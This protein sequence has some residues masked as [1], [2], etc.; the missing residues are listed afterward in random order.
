MDYLNASYRYVDKFLPSIGDLNSDILSTN[1]LTVEGF[2]FLDISWFHFFH[3]WLFLFISSFIIISLSHIYY[4]TYT[5]DSEGLIKGKRVLIVIAHPDDECMFFGPTIVNLTKKNDVDVHLM[6][7]SEGNY[8]GD[9]ETR[10]RELLSSCQELGIPLSNIR[11][12][13]N[14]HLPDDPLVDW[15]A[16]IVASLISWHVEALSMDTLL[17]FDDHGVSGHRNHIA[18]SRSVSALISE[19]RLPPSCK[20]YALKSENIFFK[21]IGF[22]IVFLKR[23]HSNIYVSSHT[24]HITIK[25]AMSKHASQYVWFRKLFVTF[26]SYCYLNTLVCLQT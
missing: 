26:S 16:E 21:Y 5:E 13:S 18:I 22:L 19:N 11:L 10:S 2:D 14:G 17:T 15:D 8:Y 24:D 20:C 9:G 7:L 6:C 1:L 3:V 25:N 23:K 4:K 12:F